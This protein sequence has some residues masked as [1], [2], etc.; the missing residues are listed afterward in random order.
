MLA[1][2]REMKGLFGWIGFAKLGRWN[3]DGKIDTG[4]S[5]VSFASYT[6]KHAQVHLPLLWTRLCEEL[7]NQD[8]LFKS[9]GLEQSEA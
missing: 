1:A 7:C 9:H 3:K 2:Q 6:C 4:G 5:E 8:F